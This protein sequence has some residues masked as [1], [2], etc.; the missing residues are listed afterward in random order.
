MLKLKIGTRG[1]KLALVQANWVK[2]GL[3]EHYGNCQIEIVP[4]KTA[5]DRIKRTPISQMG[6]KG[7]FIKEIEKALIKGEIDLAVHS[8]KDLPVELP[9]ELIISAITKR[10]DPFDVFI[11]KAYSGIENLPP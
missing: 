4:I 7:L 3:M 6:G 2:D 11:S 1:S 5:G 8:M 9:H 10:E